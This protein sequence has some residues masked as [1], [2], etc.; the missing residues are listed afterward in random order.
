LRFQGVTL[1]CVNLGGCVIPLLVCLYL[2]AVRQPPLGG[3]LAAM[4][5][6]TLA[7]FLFSRPVSGIGIAMPIL[8]A[9]LVAALAAILLAPEAS[10]VVAYIAGVCGVILGADIFNLHTIRR[11]A[12]PIASIGGAGTFDGI[13]ISGLIAVLL[14]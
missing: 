4:A 3:L 5:C 10:P 8:I 13:F 11:L 12:T 1:I 7:S 2:L 9:P 6:V 14:A